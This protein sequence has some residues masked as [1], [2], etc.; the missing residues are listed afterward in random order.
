MRLRDL[1]LL[2]IVIVT[3][4][5]LLAQEW[6]ADVTMTLVRRAIA[7]RASTQADT[8]LRDYR[9][10][11]HGFVFFLGQLGEGLSEPPKLVKTDQ[12]ELEV[13]WKAPG[14]SKQRIIGRRDRRDLPTD[15]R[16]HRDHLGIVANNFG[17]R[18]GL[19]HNTEVRDVPHPL[20]SLG[21]ELY[22]Y[23]LVDS[24]TVRLPLRTVRVYEVRALPKNPAVPGVIGTLYLDLNTAELVQFRFNFTGSSYLDETIE[25]ITIVLENGLWEGRFWLPRRQEIEIR[26]RTPFLDLP[27]RGI[28]RGT[29]E[30]DDYRFNTGISDRTFLGPAIVE[31]PGAVRDSFQWS[32][33]I[34]D[35]IESAM[36][37]SARFDLEEI[38]TQVRRL[39]SDRM[40]S[41]LATARFGA[42]SVSDL[43]HFNRVE[44]LAL[45]GG[46]VVRPGGGP[47]EIRLWGGYGV[48]DRRIK[49]RLSAGW[50]VRRVTLG[51]HAA[52]EIRD[53]GADPVIAPVLNSLLA[54]EVG[55]DYGDYYLSEAA[56]VSF[57]LDA[58]SR[59]SAALSFGVEHSVS[60]STRGSPATGRFRMNPPLGRGTLG[61]VILRLLH[62][63]ADERAG[64]GSSAGLTVEGGIGEGT[65][66]LRVVG[67]VTASKKVGGSS[68]VLRGMGGWGS[69]DLPAHRSFVLGGRG[70]LVSQQF[71]IWGG[72]RMAL[73]SLE[74]RVTVPFVSV[75]LGAWATTGD[76]IV[77]APFVKLGWAGGGLSRFA[78]WRS[79]DGVRPE[80]GLAVE[81]LHG[82]L[83]SELGS[84]P[85][86][87]GFGVTL[88]IRRDLWGIL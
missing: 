22:N 76:E 50:K 63:A 53:V 49:A 69:D 14:R 60:V 59:Q 44:G 79:S 41:G 71:R 55:N 38:R 5:A 11:A 34:G 78:P 8:G 25:D 19:G 58:A 9:A 10:R 24:L 85:R 65:R 72:R 17:D 43:V 62:R 36:A 67:S 77:I 23:T 66:Y 40:L 30:I 61:K 3:P 20:S 21:L 12:L 13:Y 68:A 33:S 86:D 1:Q 29:W 74:W 87:G 28:I 75:P 45:G 73:G 83:R 2:A 47:T 7:R 42:A 32:E 46:G 37:P 18:I 56:S 64:R 57:R 26:R 82:L 6:N 80:L 70:T 15:I 4:T 31:A 48:S 16:Y 35:A 27:A 81:W 52:R 51:I 54:Q 88:D 39:A 84:S